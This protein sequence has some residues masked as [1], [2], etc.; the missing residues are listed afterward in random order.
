MSNPFGLSVVIPVYHGVDPDHLRHALD[1]IYAQTLL[2]EEIVL[3]EDG[4]LLASQLKVLD[5]YAEWTPPLRRVVLP[6]N[7]GAGPANDAGLRAASA[8]WIAKMDADDV[9]LSVRFERQ[10][11]ALGSGSYDLVGSA[12]NEFDGSEDNIV[13]IR[14]MP[15]DHDAI[16]RYLRT[17]SP[18]NHP[19][20]VFRRDL[21]MK[22]GGYRAIP[23]LEDYE[24]VAR[25]VA[26]GARMHNLPEPLLS[27]RTGDAALQRRKARGIFVA[28]I[29]LQ[30]SLYH[31]GLVG[32]GRA[33]VN[34]VARSSYRLLPRTLMRRAYRR[35]FYR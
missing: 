30:R 17:N 35:L 12:M 18:V 25:L 15:E 5:A 13:G 33:I 24:F 14:R 9:A 19:T 26:A 34:V 31:H 11:E 2:P 3:V 8:R 23:N 28:E 7:L 4:P 22:V 6:E 29:T 10:V 27:F 16:C 1:S 21:A 20:V 32:L